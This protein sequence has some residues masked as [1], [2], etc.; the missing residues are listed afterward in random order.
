VAAGLSVVALSGA[1]IWSLLSTQPEVEL[2][3]AVASI[4]PPEAKAPVP[5]AA[6]DQP[7]VESA[8]TTVAPATTPEPAPPVVAPEQPDLPAVPTPSLTELL[9][10]GTLKTD[11]V[12]AFSTLFA[13]WDLDYAQLNGEG[14]CKR[15]SSAGLSCIFGRG[16]L[17]SIGSKDRPA[18]L[19]LIDDR[20]W[21][22]HVT[23]TRL[24][25]DGVALDFGGEVV[26]LPREQLDA[27]WHGSY[28]LLWRPPKLQRTVLRE[29]S[30]GTDVLWLRARLDQADGRP[31]ST[32]ASAVFDA[33]LA[34]RVRSF[35]TAHGLP[36]DGVV[37]RQTLLKLNS[38]TADPPVPKL[39][40]ALSSGVSLNVVHP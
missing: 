38:V 17:T 12:T 28:V 6:E 33:E 30:S 7:P 29:G 23:L 25:P 20:G 11:T 37:G 15:A 5:A 9:E 14:A 36:A 40:A 1:T 32:Q 16:N 8:P 18:V 35:Q 2:P 31:I 26:E 21:R 4:E 13:H 22:H 39:T 27:L 24:D 34:E 19:E 3:V 10:T